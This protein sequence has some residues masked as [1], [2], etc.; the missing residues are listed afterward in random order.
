MK[1]DRAAGQNPIDQL[2]VIGHP[3]DRIDGRF[4]TTGSAPYAYERH[5]VVPHQAYGYIIGSAVVKGR[6]TRMDVARAKAAPGVLAIVTTLEMPALKNGPRNTAKLFGGPEISQY[7]QATAI[8]VA[9]TFEQARAAAALIDTDYDHDEGQF[10]LK[11]AQHGARPVPATNGS[12]AD[13]IGDFER[14]FLPLQRALMRR[15]P[16]RIRRM[17]DGAPCNNRRMGRRKTDDLDLKP[18]DRLEPA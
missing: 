10:D 11:Q 8:V 1:F 17:P 2:H 4:K 3:L 7:H 16:H 15:T 13:R 14:H 9:E 5:D 12:R 6:I 18:D